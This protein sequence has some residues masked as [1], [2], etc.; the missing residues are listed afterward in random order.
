MNHSTC[1]VDGCE[2]PTEKVTGMCAMHRKRYYRNGSTQTTKPIG[3]PYR[4]STGYLGVWVPGHEMAGHDG[5]AL[6]HRVVLFDALGLGPHQCHWCSKVINW[7]R[8]L[9]VDHVNTI[10][11]DN[12]AENLVPACHRCNTQ[13]HRWEDATASPVSP[14]T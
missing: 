6:H 10:R 11:H 12:R 9:H 13:R 3:Q 7:R 4:K 2:K 14:T 8:G 1:S 5:K